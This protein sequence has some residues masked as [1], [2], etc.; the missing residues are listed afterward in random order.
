MKTIGIDIGATTTRCICQKDKEILK[1][2]YRETPKDTKQIKEMLY[3]LLQECWMPDVEAVGIGAAGQISEDGRILLFAPNIGVRGLS[4]AS[5]LENRFKRRVFLENDV[6]CAAVAEAELGAAKGEKD[7][8]CIFVGTGIGGAAYING[9]LLRGA[10]NV[11]GEFGHLKIGKDEVCGCG[12]R[13]CFEAVVSGPSIIH[14]AQTLTRKRMDISSIESAY[15]EGA[16]FA[17]EV[18]DWAANA[19]C[20]GLSSLVNIFNP[21]LIVLGGGVIEAAP[22][23]LELVKSRI[24]DH[25]LEAS[26]KGM[27][28]KM[29]ELGKWA[30]AI[31]AALFACR[32]GSSP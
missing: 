28:I 16:P 29:A 2:A 19:L 5:V 31:G 12:A 13:G 15:R 30:G 32:Q 6:R 17:K 11:A 4:L 22:S 26:Y 10:K 3:Y 24:K 20:L 8:L 18:M 23:L 14:R 21:S 9:S 1:R 25:C 27:R 7:F